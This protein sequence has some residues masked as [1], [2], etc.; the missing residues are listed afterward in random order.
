[1]KLFIRFIFLLIL[2][3]SCKKEY[4]CP[5]YQSAFIHDPKLRQAYFLPFNPDGT[6]KEFKSRK[7]RKTGLAKNDL[8]TKVRNIAKPKQNVIPIYKPLDIDPDSVVFTV[9]ASDEVF[10]DLNE[11]LLLAEDLGLKETIAVSEDSLALDSGAFK[12]KYHYNWD[13]YFY[14]LHFAKYL[15][16]PM[17]AL[18]VPQDSLAVVELETEEPKEDWNWDI[19]S[20]ATQLGGKSKK[21]KKWKSW[22]KRKKSKRVEAKEINPAKD[23]ESEEDLLKD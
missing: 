14:L 7:N 4:T 19:E 1:M 10:D 15:P 8:F 21:R 13:Q 20:S 22:F 17:P 9:D 5:A 18:E 2:C 16:E 6:P 23:E 3:G 12:S 11:D